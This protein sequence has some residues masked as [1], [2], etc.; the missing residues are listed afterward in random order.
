L[1]TEIGSKGL[2]GCEGI[3]WNAENQVYS[4]YLL[5][6]RMWD[7]LHILRLEYLNQGIMDSIGYEKY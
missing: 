4:I 1:G 6:K 7:K 3:S 2:R 5:K